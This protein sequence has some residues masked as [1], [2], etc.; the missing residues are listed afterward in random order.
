MVPFFRDK[1]IV[2]AEAS[3]LG[4]IVGLEGDIQIVRARHNRQRFS[5]STNDPLRVGI[6]KLYFVEATLGR[7]FQV[8]FGKIQSNQVIG[9]CL[10][11]PLTVQISPIFAGIVGRVD[12]AGRLSQFWCTTTTR[13]GNALKLGGAAVLDE[14][15]ATYFLLYFTIDQNSHNFGYPTFAS[16]H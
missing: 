14:A 12:W 1:C 3:I 16:E 7:V 8:N 2:C 15:G 10:D 9:R 6:R 4:R 13:F 5:S 11:L